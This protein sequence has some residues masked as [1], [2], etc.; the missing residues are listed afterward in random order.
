MLCKV[1]IYLFRYIIIWIL[2]VSLLLT[3]KCMIRVDDVSYD[4]WSAA[5]FEWLKDMPSISAIFV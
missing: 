4:E 5:I 2:Q 1:H 3:R